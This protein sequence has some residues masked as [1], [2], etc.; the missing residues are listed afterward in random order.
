MIKLGLSIL[1]YKYR[2]RGWFEV[3]GEMYETL[4]S[5]LKLNGEIPHG[6]LF[7]SRDSKD[8]GQYSFVHFG[9]YLS[10]KEQTIFLETI[11]ECAKIESNYSDCLDFI[12]GEF[13]VSEL[14]NQF[15]ALRI[16]IGHG[17]YNIEEA[18]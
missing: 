10:V 13:L 6:W 5:L 8:Y 9:N 18:D 3:D 11:T 2:I 15:P 4:Y 7:Q 12:E 16:S 17:S 1:M 14:N